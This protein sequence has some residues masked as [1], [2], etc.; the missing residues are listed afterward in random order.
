ME[1]IKQGSYNNVDKFGELSI[2]FETISKHY[3]NFYL[4]WKYLDM[5]VQ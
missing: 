5:A 4:S 2:Q 1:T 3:T